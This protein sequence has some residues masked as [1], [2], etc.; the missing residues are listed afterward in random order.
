VVQVAAETP[1]QGL[2]QS[3]QPAIGAALQ[4]DAMKLIVQLHAGGDV[5][6]SLLQAPDDLAQA[7][8]LN[9]GRLGGLVEGQGF[10][11]GEDR[12]DVS[13]LNRGHLG[14]A[15]AAARLSGEHTLAG[16]PDEGFADW[17]AADAEFRGDGCVA[18]LGSRGE[19]SALNALEELEIDL[20]T[21]RVPSDPGLHDES[22][23]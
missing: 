12:A 14:Q 10:Q 5:A 6:S 1:A 8:E 16:E 15:K 4:E 22:R 21:E 2:E 13:Q 7:A 19:A 20:V 11:R 9:V 3:E 17:S 23:I 18:E